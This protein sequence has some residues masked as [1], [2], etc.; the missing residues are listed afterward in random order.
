MLADADW[1][2]L[3]AAP[4]EQVQKQRGGA[5]ISI[6]DP[7]THVFVVSAGWAIRYRVMQDGRR[8]IVNVMLPGDCFDL[9]AMIETSADHAVEAITPLGLLRV[10]REEFLNALRLNA[11]LATAFWWAAVQEES[12]LREQIVR[13]GRRSGRERLAHLVLEIQR[14]LLLAGVSEGNTVSWPLSRELLADMLGL[15]PVHISRSFAALRRMGL[16]RTMSGAVH[17]LDKARLAALAQFDASYL[18][19]ETPARLG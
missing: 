6:G 15:S 4:F 3:T 14:R 2:P 8:Q 1:S 13:L 7:L 12:V 17:I 19:A 16:V 10:R 18:H 11:R 5:V 9:Q